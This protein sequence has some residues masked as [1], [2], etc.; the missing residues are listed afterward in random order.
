MITENHKKESMSRAMIQAIAG[1]CGMTCSYSNFDYGIDIRI[2]DV[3]QR[4]DGDQVRYIDAGFNIA[5]QAKSTQIATT[6]GD[7]IKYDLDVK[8]YNDLRDVNV[9]EP[10]ILVLLILHENESE[11][12]H[13]SEEEMIMKRCLY[14][15]SLRGWDP[16]DNK[17]TIR[18]NIPR[19]NLFTEEALMELMEKRK[20]GIDL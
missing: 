1:K 10:R 8:N 5:I 3:A 15:V 2:H 20:G 11:W 9:G 17:N 12:L 6:D 18:I 14:W 19:S 7:C 13:L 16:T 4:M